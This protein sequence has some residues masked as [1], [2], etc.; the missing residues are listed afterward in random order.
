MFA[1]YCGKICDIL[2]LTMKKKIEIFMFITNI[3]KN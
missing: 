1:K 3:T 2:Q